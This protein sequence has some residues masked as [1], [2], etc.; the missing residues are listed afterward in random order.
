MAVR[1]VRTPA[2]R[3]RTHGRASMLTTAWSRG[4]DRPVDQR[5]PRGA[6]AGMRLTRWTIF[7]LL[8][9]DHEE[10]NAETL[11]GNGE[12]TMT[13]IREML[14]LGVYYARNKQWNNAVPVFAKALEQVYQNATG[15]LE[16][17]PGS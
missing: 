7:G 3:S 17:L 15:N 13:T 5:H 12:R 10:T 11:H 1:Q 9:V 6:S 8:S 14:E 4:A 16:D 2:R